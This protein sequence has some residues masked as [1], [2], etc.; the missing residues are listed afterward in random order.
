M[1]S[2]GKQFNNKNYDLYFEWSD[3][4]IYYSELIWKIYKEGAGIEIGSLQKL[5]DFNLDNPAV[6]QK[7]K[8]RY[9]DKIPMNE[10][11]ISLAAI[12]NSNLLYTVAE[13]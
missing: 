1:K 10:K 7:L 4:R 12:F 2:K 3:D 9:G 6:K 13:N 8:E 11:V 5:S